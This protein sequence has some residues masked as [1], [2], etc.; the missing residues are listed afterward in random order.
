MRESVACCLCCVKVKNVF[1][2]SFLLFQRSVTPG[3]H[4]SVRRWKQRKNVSAVSLFLVDELHLIGGPK[5]AT[6]EVICS[7]MRYI[8][9][10]VNSCT[11]CS[12]R[13]FAR[14]FRSGLHQQQH[15]QP[16]QVMQAPG[17][18]KYAVVPIDFLGCEVGS[19]SSSDPPIVFLIDR[20]GC[21]KLIK[22]VRAT[23]WECISAYMA[24]SQV[25]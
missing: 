16:D 11:A 13:V 2:A 3:A 12:A 24:C 4:P 10:Q 15:R 23:T 21:A 9:S 18:F 20:R 8:A 17:M 22:R 14:K 6:I 7:R 5:G 25:L 19:L 1:Q